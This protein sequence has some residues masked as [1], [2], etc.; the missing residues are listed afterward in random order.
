[1]QGGSFMSDKSVALFFFADYSFKFNCVPLT[2]WLVAGNFGLL[3][4]HPHISA[5]TPHTHT[6]QR[7]PPG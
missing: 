3:A 2:T 4:Q 1:M 7:L 5:A 6:H